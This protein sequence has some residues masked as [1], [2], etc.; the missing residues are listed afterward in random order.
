LHENISYEVILERPVPEGVTANGYVIHSDR[1]V[2][3]G[4]GSNHG[5]QVYRLI[6]ATDS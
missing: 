2:Y 1:E 6:D 5:S 3:L 4:S